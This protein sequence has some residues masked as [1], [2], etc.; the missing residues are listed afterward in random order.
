MRSKNES[1]LSEVEKKIK[2]T[3]YLILADY[4][5]LNVNEI[6]LLRRELKHK[7]AELKVIKN[8][9]SSILFK[10]IGIEGMDEYLAGP[11]AVAFCMGDEVISSKI[12]TDFAREHE[13]LKI[14]AGLL[15]KH[16]LDVSK[17]E[18]IAKL[19]GREVL[20]SKLITVM[21]FPVLMLACLLGEPMQYLLG[22]ITAKVQKGTGSDKPKE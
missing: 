17:I 5:G 10:K 8:T 4:R 18:A 1:I 14:K 6:G 19:P 16:L 7:S 13:G 2:D 9:L 22:T 3:R 11:I 21:Q 20:L 12:L 15:N